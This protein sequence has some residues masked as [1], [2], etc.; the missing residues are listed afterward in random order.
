M[1][2]A[3][4]LQSRACA[5]DPCCRLETPLPA[6]QNSEE[7]PPSGS[8][9]RW[10]ENRWLMLFVAVVVSGASAAIS[11]RLLERFPMRE[12]VE[13]F[14]SQA[15]QVGIPSPWLDTASALHRGVVWWSAFGWFYPVALR[16]G[17]LRTV[18]WI[19]LAAIGVPIADAIWSKSPTGNEIRFLLPVLLPC[20]T[21]VGRRTRPWMAIPASVAFIVVGYFSSRIGSWDLNLSIAVQTLPYAAILIFG[22]NLIPR[23]PATEAT[24]E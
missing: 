5:D 19:G 9:W 24:T 15:A 4:S 17:F 18:V 3:E 14:F 13:L 11:F 2:Y 12:L 23:Q 22:T 10:M 1:D 16:L 8:R 6:P 7:P 21:M 20:V